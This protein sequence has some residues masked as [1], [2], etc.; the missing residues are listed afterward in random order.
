MYFVII[1]ACV[2]PYIENNLG[3]TTQRSRPA[4]W[5]C[6][7]TKLYRAQLVFLS[8]VAGSDATGFNAGPKL[9]SSNLHALKAAVWERHSPSSTQRQ[10][11]KKL[12]SRTAAGI[13]SPEGVTF[14][15]LQPLGEGQIS[16]GSFQQRRLRSHDWKLPATLSTML[17]GF[18]FHDFALKYC[19]DNDKKKSPLF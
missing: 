12:G 5:V 16:T 9:I 10:H 19:Y 15:S 6:S 3:R 1:A 7:G 18:Q 8:P 11:W 13:A 2:C 14:H 17:H 4:A